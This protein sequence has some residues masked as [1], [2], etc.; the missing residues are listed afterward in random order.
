MMGDDAYAELARW[1]WTGLANH[2][3]QATVFAAFA[4]LA[5]V[6]LGRG[7][8]RARSV[9]WMVA[10][11]KFALP[12]A[13]FGYLGSLAG[14]GTTLPTSEALAPSG[15]AVVWTIVEPVRATAATVE[16]EPSRAGA[17]FLVLTAIWAVGAAA[18]FAYWC[19]QRH[20]LSLAIGV[21]R[22]LDRGR[23]RDAL[24]RARLRLGVRREIG[25]VVSPQVTEPGVWRVLRPVV[26][27][28]VGVGEAL[29]DDELE[30]VM[31]HEA[32]HVARRDNLVA[33]LQMALCC[34]FWFHP[35]VWAI[36][37]KLLA[38][39]E[40]ACD[41][42][43]IGAG[44]RARVY[45][46]GLLKVF[47]FAIG[48]QPAGVS[49]AT[50]SHLGRRIDDIMNSSERISTNWHRAVIA[51]VALA[52]VGVSATAAALGGA[53]DQK[54]EVR[55]VVIERGPG[56]PGPELTAAAATAPTWAVLRYDN[57]AGAP[58][59]I[60]D[61]QVK[62]VPAE[63]VAAGEAGRKIVMQ[64]TEKG[65]PPPADAKGG[66]PGEQKLTISFPE[67]DADGNVPVLY[68]SLTNTS[69]KQ[70]TG[71]QLGGGAGEETQFFFA[72]NRPIEP[73]AT[74]Q[75]AAPVGMPLVNSAG[76]FVLGVKG[77]KFGDGQTWGVYGEP[78][79]MMFRHE[80]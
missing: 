24:D 51:A 18:A 54:R 67:T 78:H 62:R 41:E 47:R 17:I 4:A 76:D 30:A 28:P 45:A 66:V 52:M 8:A 72:F 10:S 1:A 9:V 74:F 38:E 57:A 35:V 23:E 63:Q 49:C 60:T 34:V 55:D 29:S 6:A 42:A 68:V 12:L 19:A 46:T 31:M 13:L 3:W 26:V 37:R 53:Q 70:I 22:R 21:G 39:R 50:G 71:Y 44:G 7:P 56:G 58:L 61:A 5:S 16:A 65:V 2:L 27:L 79:D 75:I 11:A 25:L 40:R 69:G 36:D 33:N 64:R 77:V 59:E 80:N 14:V 20:V 43:V 73:G 15:A 32:A 48:W